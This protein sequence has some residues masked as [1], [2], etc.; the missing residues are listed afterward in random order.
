MS[1]AAPRG[2][3]LVIDGI[4][5]CGKST[6]AVELA[7]WLA[8]RSGGEVLHLR[9]PGSTALGEGLRSLLLS[10][11]VEITAPV[12]TLL[13]TAA[14]R[15][16]LH[17]RVAP[18]LARGADVVCERFHGSTFAYQ[19]VAG[20]EDETRLLDLLQTWAGEPHPDLTLWLDMDVE[21]ALERRGAARD[22]IEDKGAAFQRQVA[23]GFARYAERT[24]DV[25]RVDGDGT[26][27]QVHERI[28]E[29]VTR[30]LA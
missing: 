12:E 26:M 19:A 25:L 24:E 9:E 4:D 23:T 16:M 14:R 3:F 17:E 5:G 15:Q 27:E 28:V 21:R 20:G 2:R 30:V 18:A 13:F 11:E 7:R 8:E 1:S 29:E 6:Q 10:R 22:R